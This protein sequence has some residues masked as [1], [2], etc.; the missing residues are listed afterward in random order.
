M[1][2]LSEIVNNDDLVFDEASL[3]AILGFDAVQG[4]DGS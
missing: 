3:E 4:F 1:I 2:V